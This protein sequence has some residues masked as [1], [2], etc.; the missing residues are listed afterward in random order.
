MLEEQA[1]AVR[2]VPAT[3]QTAE[4]PLLQ[5]R[6]RDRRP[7]EGDRAFEHGLGALIDGLARHLPGQE[8]ERA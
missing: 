4:Y 1:A 3:G 7:P 8:G 6:A 2:D 5:C